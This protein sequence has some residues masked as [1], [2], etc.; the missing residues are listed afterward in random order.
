MIEQGFGNI[1][2]MASIGALPCVLGGS[3]YDTTKAGVVKM[4]ILAAARLA[5]HGVRVNAICPGIH[6]APLAES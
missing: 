5:P 4:T 1:I 6:L 3:A 2:N